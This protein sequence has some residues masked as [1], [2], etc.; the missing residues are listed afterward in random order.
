MTT[1]TD[2]SALASLWVDAPDTRP[3]G[4]V[5][6][7]LAFAGR[8]VLKI[9]LVPEQLADIIG[10]PIL[11]TLLFTYL[12]GGALAGSTSAYLH[13]LLP[14]TVVL[15]LVF[16]TIYSGATLN[17]D[18]A[19]GAF[20]R[21]RSLPIWRPAPIVG[22]LIGDVARYLVAA[23][24][25]MGMG[26]VMGYRTNAGWLPVVGAVGL[27]VIFALSVSWV[28]TTIGLLVRTPQTVMNL[29]FI[30]LMPLTFISDV[31]V[32]PR[33]MPDWLRTVSGA[34]PITHLTTATRALMGGTAAGT[35]IGWV[36][37]ASAAI[38][39]VFATTTLLLYRRA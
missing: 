12:F 5:R 4:A 28:W 18:L 27:V 21:F 7:S 26:L 1:A 32:D 38:T 15:A 22:A 13:Y 23:A 19:T 6:A 20:D 16:V 9:K 8:A 35:E 31:F 39:A 34:N 37:I 10:I 25:V 3:S 29:G 24:L 30:I 14:G 33:T 36:L 11:F 17:R 2:T